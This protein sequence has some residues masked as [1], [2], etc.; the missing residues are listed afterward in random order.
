M[1]SSP[2]RSPKAGTAAPAMVSA[3]AVTMGRPMAKPWACGVTDSGFGKTGWA[4]FPKTSPLNQRVVGGA[5]PEGGRGGRG[6]IGRARQAGERRGEVG[7]GRRR[8][9]RGR[10]R[11]A[12]HRRAAR[13]EEH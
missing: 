5:S 9:A 12:V 1:R 13:D 6:L 11:G 3:V 8:A 10:T 7:P 2:K 4:V